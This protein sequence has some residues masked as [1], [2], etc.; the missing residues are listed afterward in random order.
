MQKA[1]GSICFSSCFRMAG[2]VWVAIS[3]ST[4]VLFNCPLW[5]WHL[6]KWMCSPGVSSEWYTHS[7]ACCLC[8]H[9]CTA[10]LH[11]SASMHAHMNGHMQEISPQGGFRPR[12]TIETFSAHSSLSLQSLRRNKRLFFISSVV[13]ALCLTC[14]V[15][16]MLETINLQ[17]LVSV[18]RLQRHKLPFSVPS[19]SLF[20]R[21]L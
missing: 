7:T 21:P 1:C 5:Q 12:Y 15:R 13:V 9:A 16:H 2:R 4:P 17:S 18:Q 20:C 3:T 6:L 10:V 11:N 19:P 14:A 8:V